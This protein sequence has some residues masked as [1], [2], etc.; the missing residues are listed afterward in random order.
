[1][2]FSVVWICQYVFNEILLDSLSCGHCINN[3]IETDR[4]KQLWLKYDYNDIRYIIV[5]D[6]HS[7]IDLINTIMSIADE[8]LDEQIDTGSP[9][10]IQKYILISKILVLDEI[11]KDW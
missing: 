6:S 10:I 7:R 3:S 5:P 1:M 11:R 4:Y 8:Q 2:R 9:T